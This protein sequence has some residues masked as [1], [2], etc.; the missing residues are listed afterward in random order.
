MSIMGNG[1]CP[2]KRGSVVSCQYAVLVELY[3]WLDGSQELATKTPRALLET[4][5]PV[6]ISTPFTI[7]AYQVSLA[8]PSFSA[9]E[10]AEA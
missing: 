6:F 7:D 5:E 1:E 9:P 2:F 4:G 8:I 3:G 10:A